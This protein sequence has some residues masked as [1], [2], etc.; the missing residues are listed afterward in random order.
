MFIKRQATE[1]L[2]FTRKFIISSISVVYI[3]CIEYKFQVLY[4]Y[5]QNTIIAEKFSEV[6]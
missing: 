1:I 5:K 2:T 3:K 6:I 4:W